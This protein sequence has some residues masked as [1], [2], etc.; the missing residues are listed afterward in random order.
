MYK[1]GGTIVKK[2][3]FLFILF[4]FGVSL[5]VVPQNLKVTSF[6]RTN[7]LSASRFEKKDINGEPCG[8]I[9]V[10]LP[11]NDGKFVGNVVGSI[12]KNGEWWVYMTKG[13]KRVTIKTSQYPPLIYEFDETVLSNVTYRMTVMRETTHEFE[14]PQK[15][16]KIVDISYFTKGNTWEKELYARA[17]GVEYNIDIESKCIDIVEQDDF[18]GNG[19]VDALIEEDACGG[20]IAMYGYYIVSYSE[21]GYFT[22]SNAVWGNGYTVEDWKSN[23]SILII[24]A[25][26][27]Y[28]NDEM[29]T[30][31]ERYVLKDGKME[32]VETMKKQL[33][34][35]IKELKSSD[36][37]HE[38]EKHLRLKYDLDGNGITDFF[39]C[40]YWSRWGSMMIRRF[41]L[42]GNEIKD[43]CLNV[44]IKRIGILSSKTNG[45]HDLVLDEDEI[46]KWNGKK[47]VFPKF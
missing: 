43:D 28:D 47:Y 40:Y 14:N 31:K 23:K 26:V 34:V 1:D 46:I 20:T 45:Y 25:N 39:E 9:K 35:S 30:K 6:K 19:I 32:L 10:W 37:H 17:N 41:V 3:M 5:T 38:D 27:G 2:T 4:V 21:N 13:S 29:D 36:F 12:F 7:D 33:V 11:V 18:D 24:D 42:N 22:I 44:G 8:L 15:A 16:L